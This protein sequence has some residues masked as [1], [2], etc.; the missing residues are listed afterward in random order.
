M[1]L[2][3]SDLVQI[4]ELIEHAS[5]HQQEYGDNFFVFLSKHYG[6]L[7]AEHEKN[8]QEEVPDHEQLPFQ[9]SAHTG[10]VMAVF[11]HVTGWDL[12]LTPNPPRTGIN[13]IYLD[14]PSDPFSRGVFQPP[15]FA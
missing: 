6:E 7:K 15:Q 4:D 11:D 3:F 8:H 1:H 5:F 10:V 12:T 9:Y 13:S 2:G 14:T